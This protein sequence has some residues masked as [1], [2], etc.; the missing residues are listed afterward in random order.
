MTEEKRE[1]TEEAIALP[2]SAENPSQENEEKKLSLRA[3]L[4]IGGAALLLICGVIFGALLFSEKLQVADRVLYAVLDD[5]GLGKTLFYS[6]DESLGSASGNVKKRITSFGGEWDVTLT[7]TG[8]LYLLHERKAESLSAE[9]TDVLLASEGGAVLYLKASGE[10]YFV[11]GEEASFICRESAATLEKWSISPSGA[12][13][14]YYSEQDEKAYLYANGAT[15]LLQLEN[16]DGISPLGVSDD[17]AHLYY[18]DAEG[19]SLY[20]ASKAGGATKLSASFSTADPVHFNRSLSQIVFTESNSYSYYSVSGDVK[21]KLSSGVATP[22]Q[23][24]GEGVLEGERA[25]IH[26]FSTF[27]ARYYLVRLDDVQ[28]LRYLDSQF[29]L[30]KCASDVF[31]ARESADGKTLFL[32]RRTD[33]RFRIYQMSLSDEKRAETLVA[34]GVMEYAVGAEGSE[35]YYVTRGNKLYLRS[36]NT[37]TLLTEDADK[38]FVSPQGEVFWSTPT[39]QSGVL[40]SLLKDGKPIRITANLKDLRFTETDVYVLVFSAEGEQWNRLSGEKLIALS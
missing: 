27:A 17:G 16:E 6:G 22:L 3:R 9:A 5:V 2:Q 1:N 39:S 20:H 29:T 25:R 37:S 31:D 19:T 24:T 30:T 40:L 35:I 21:K 36:K 18:L 7:D 23:K 15:E 13:V 14:F 26:S 12:C 11:R 28:S 32:I 38:L 4:L 10:V 33:D 8:E 34:S